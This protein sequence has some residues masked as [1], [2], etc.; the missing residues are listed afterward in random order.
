VRRTPQSSGPSA[1]EIPIFQSAVLSRFQTGDAAILPPRSRQAAGLAVGCAMSLF[2]DCLDLDQLDARLCSAPILTAE[3]MSGVVATSCPRLALL[4]HTEPAA[5]AEQ[6]IRLGAWTDAAFALLALELPQWQLRRLAYDD[7]EWHCALSRQR[8]MPE[9]L[10]QSIEA[11]H[12][13]LPI[14]ILRAFV[15]ARRVSAPSTRSSVPA[16]PRAANDLYEPMC[17]GNFG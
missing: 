13:D 10:D 5:R 2:S 6:M 12:A 4:Q 14:A 9:W 3:L 8:E 7:G 1:Y 17:S 11:H 15:S 16:A